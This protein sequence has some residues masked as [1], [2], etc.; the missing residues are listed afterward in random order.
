MDMRV[1]AAGD[2][3]LARG[4]D[5]PPGAERGEA[6]RRADRGDLLAGDADIGRLGPEGR[7][8]SAAGDDDVEHVEPPMMAMP[9]R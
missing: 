7:T 8:A 2:D 6:A 9:A 5:D 3:D 4:V 1:D